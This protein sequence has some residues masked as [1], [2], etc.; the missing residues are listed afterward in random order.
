MTALNLIVQGVASNR[1]SDR[2]ARTLL[3]AVSMAM[4][5]EQR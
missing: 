2:R 5:A 4:Q 3:H 1:I